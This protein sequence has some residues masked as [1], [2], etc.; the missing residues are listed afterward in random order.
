MGAAAGF[1]PLPIPAAFVQ[2]STGLALRNALGLGTPVE[3][4][5]Q[6]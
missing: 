3:V 4:F 1:T 2:R 6:Q 5:V